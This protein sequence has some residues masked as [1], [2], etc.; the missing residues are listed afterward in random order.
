M[1]LSIFHYFPWGI[2]SDG[3]IERWAEQWKTLI[4]AIEREVEEA[5]EI[6]RPLK[7]M[8]FNLMEVSTQ[9]VTFDIVYVDLAFQMMGSYLR[10]ITSS[11]L[12]RQVREPNYNLNSDNTNQTWINFERILYVSLYHPDLGLDV[13]SDPYFH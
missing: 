7:T 1:I 13:K 8:N 11:M 9:E 4:R 5:D 12:Y 10:W 2:G 3:G 6:V